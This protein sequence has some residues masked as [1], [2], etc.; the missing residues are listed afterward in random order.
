MRIDPARHFGLRECPSCACE[1]P[2]NENRC[3][4]CGY[5]FPSPTRTQ[6]SLRVGGALVMLAILLLGLLRLLR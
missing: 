5:L 3:P 6:R 2:A 1:V 4:I